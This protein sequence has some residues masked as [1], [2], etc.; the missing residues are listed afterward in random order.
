[1]IPTNLLTELLDMVEDL[2]GIFSLYPLNLFL[3]GSV[4]GIGFAIL[5]RAKKVAR[6]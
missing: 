4:I 3:L 1:M 2:L 6:G 5:R